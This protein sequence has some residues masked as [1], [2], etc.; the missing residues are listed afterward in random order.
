MNTLLLVLQRFITNIRDVIQSEKAYLFIDVVEQDIYPDYYAIIPLPISM[1]FI[2]RRLRN[3]YYRQVRARFIQDS[4]NYSI[5]FFLKKTKTSKIDGF[6]QSITFINLSG[7]I[8]EFM[9]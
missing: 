8:F 2:L 3:N 1:N 6:R 5:F 9:I 7:K 4:L